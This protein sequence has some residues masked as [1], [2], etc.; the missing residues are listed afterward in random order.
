M[1]LSPG[2]YVMKDGPLHVVNSAKL[3][4]SDVTIF[5]SGDRARI[6]FDRG[7]TIR[8]EGATSGPTAGMLIMEGR[9]SRLSRTHDILSNDARQLVGTIYLPRS[10]LKVDAASTVA[11]QSAYTAIVARRVHLFGQSRVILR[12]N[13]HLTDVPVPSGI[14]GAGQP[15][16][17]VQ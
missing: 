6:V 13:Y 1:T 9:G 10:V 14:K 11:D 4:G 7:T 3:T 17:L 8:L 15:A 12:T 5:L 16:H 2:V